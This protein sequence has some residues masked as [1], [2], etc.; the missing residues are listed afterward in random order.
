M[1]LYHYQATDPAGKLVRGLVDAGSR[2]T[3]YEKL[4]GRGLYPTQVQED[5]GG[6]RLRLGQGRGGRADDALAYSMLQLGALLRAGIPMDEALE[7]LAQNS[8][9]PRLGRAMARVRV[10]LR[11]GDSLAASMAEEDVFPPMLIRLV[12]AGEEAGKPAEILDRYAEYLARELEH[13]RAL[14]GALT[15]PIMLV[16]LSTLLLF[17][18]MAFLTPVL[19]EMYAAID[20]EL[21]WL[22]R[23][24]VA[25]GEVV[26][27][28]GPLVLLA[29]VV[30]AMGTVRLVPATVLDRLKLSLPLLGPLNRCGLMSRWARTL[31]ML[32]GAGVPLVR[33]MAMS[34]E[35]VQNAALE[36]ELRAAETAVE[37]GESLAQAMSRA[38]LVPPLL[39]QFLRTGVQSGQLEPMLRSASAFY[40]RELERRRSLLVR[41]LEPALI[42][43]MG[44]M[45][46]ALVLS[47]L[48]PLSD[49]ASRVMQ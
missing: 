40:E 1:P 30:L 36:L 22:T 25:S 8:E 4:R 45:V 16:V 44:L 34:R 28:F 43:G 46:G 33:A 35:V 13:H 5:V 48:L 31:G 19:R 37:R 3:A 21:P 29:V 6:G 17:G 2:A 32:H 38:Y 42:L 49:L 10:R 23:T 39:Q 47:V 9:N 27:R 15:Y 14:V 26:R 12:Q 24:V 7:S 20:A 11:E 41:Y 18:L